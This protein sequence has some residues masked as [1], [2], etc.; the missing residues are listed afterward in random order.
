VVLPADLGDG[1]RF[2]DPELTRIELIGDACDKLKSGKVKA[3]QIVSGCPTEPA[4]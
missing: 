1:W 2:M 4:K 3:V